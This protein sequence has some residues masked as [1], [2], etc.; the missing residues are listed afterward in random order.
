MLA[1]NYMRSGVSYRHL[2]ALDHTFVQNTAPLYRRLRN[3][4]KWEFQSKKV[5]FKAIS[6]DATPG[7]QSSGSFTKIS[8]AVRIAMGIWDE[9]QTAQ[10]AID[11]GQK[12]YRF[13]GQSAPQ[14]LKESRVYAEFCLSIN[15]DGEKIK[16][17]CLQN[18]MTRRN[19][20][21]VS[22]DGQS[23]LE[24]IESQMPVTELSLKEGD[25]GRYVDGTVNIPIMPFG[26]LSLSNEDAAA[27]LKRESLPSSH[28]ALVES[29]AKGRDLNSVLKLFFRIRRE[30]SSRSGYVLENIHLH[31]TP[32]HSAG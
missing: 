18:G 7:S 11:N 16:V 6:P 31:H 15:L 10:F 9:N 21:L 22:T 3:C 8:T 5:T 20:I 25:V 2:V 24:V 26:R 17:S 1:L 12:S 28:T 32:Y 27:I 14:E 29:L 4:K 30:S 19:L 23:C 13:K